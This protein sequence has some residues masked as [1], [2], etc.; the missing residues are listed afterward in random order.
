MADRKIFFAFLAIILA[1]MVGAAALIILPM[2][3]ADE[4]RPSPRVI[5][6]TAE[7][8]PFLLTQSQITGVL[9]HYDRPC[10][11]VSFPVNDEEATARRHPE[12]G[13][14]GGVDEDGVGA[15]LDTQSLGHGVN[16]GSKCLVGGSARSH[17]AP[18]ASCAY[19]TETEDSERTG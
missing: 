12:H 7:V 16:E 11:I 9:A 6:E 14:G 5:K 15:S 4:F 8:Q 2:L 17:Q 18:E 19:E 10:I 13:R 1:M 3:E